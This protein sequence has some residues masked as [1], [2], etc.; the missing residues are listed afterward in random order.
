VLLFNFDVTSSQSRERLGVIL[1]ETLV[2]SI[3]GIKEVVVLKTFLAERDMVASSD[4]ELTNLP[5]CRVA[6]CPKH[7]VKRGPLECGDNLAGFRSLLK[8]MRECY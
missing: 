1:P 7:V 2:E 5:G 6:G 8:S 4:H 3:P